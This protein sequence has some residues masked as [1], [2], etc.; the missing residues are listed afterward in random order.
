M[1]ATA[2]AQAQAA[3]TRPAG[4]TLRIGELA[5]LTGTTPRTIRYYEEI[6][7]LD[8]GR[9]REQG[10][11][12]AYTQADVDRVRE[13]IRLRDLLGLSLD[14]LSRLLDAESARAHLREE[15]KHTEAPA[16]RRRILEQL[17]QHI[18]SQLELVHSRLA[19]LNDLAVE[20]TDKQQLVAQR[21][22]EIDEQ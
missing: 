8:P 5:E 15:L 2:D 3:E 11:H 1:S 4:K 17:G 10:K 7:L 6:G 14:Q 21:I 16:E 22:R 13:I 18:G 19:E 20:L 12:R 9:E